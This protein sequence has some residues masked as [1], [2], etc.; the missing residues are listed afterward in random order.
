M[1]FVGKKSFHLIQS[2]IFMHR[3]VIN[4]TVSKPETHSSPGRY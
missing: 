3:K 2:A 4:W 1:S